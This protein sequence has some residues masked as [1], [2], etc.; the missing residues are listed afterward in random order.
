LVPRGPDDDEL[1]WVLPFHKLLDAAPAAAR[2]YP[3]GRVS[4]FRLDLAGT[5][6]TSC[7]LAELSL[8]RDDD[9]PIKPGRILGGLVPAGREIVEVAARWHGNELATPV[10]AGGQYLFGAQFPA[11]AVVELHGRKRNGDI[12]HPAMGRR[13]EVA[14]DM[15]DVDFD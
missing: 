7:R 4:H 10:L 14:R 11:R 5:V 6:G 3:V 1:I 9:R 8:T 12:V 13:I 15:L 2:R